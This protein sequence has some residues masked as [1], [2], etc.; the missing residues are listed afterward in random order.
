MRL[1]NIWISN[2]TT[3]M[4]RHH[5]ERLY[6]S[7]NCKQKRGQR[8]FSGNPPKL[9]SFNQQNSEALTPIKEGSRIEKNPH[10]KAPTR[11]I[12][13]LWFTDPS[14][15]LLACKGKWFHRP[16]PSHVIMGANL[17]VP[18]C[19]SRGC[20]FGPQIHAQ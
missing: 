9:F 3:R 10:S 4:V 17:N 7:E 12:H 2:R 16:H 15:G 13:G 18:W 14:A 20:Y 1:R 5:W 8:L 11:T 6:S 19:R